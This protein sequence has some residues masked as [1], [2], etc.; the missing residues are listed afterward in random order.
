M[1]T[2]AVT[3]GIAMG[4]STFCRVSED[5]GPSVGLVCQLFDADL[6][7]S[8]LLTDPAITCTIAADFG[9]DILSPDGQIDRPR[10]RERVFNSAEQRAVL[11]NIL[12]PVVRKRFAEQRHCANAGGGV[13]VF[14]ADIPLLYES[15]YCFE[16]DYVLVV[17]SSAGVQM[18]RLLGR[19]GMTETIAA[20]VIAS[21]LPTDEKIARADVVL[22]NDGTE[23]QFTEQID[24]FYQWLKKKTN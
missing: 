17:A 21:Q 19:K 10:L 7:V 15:E 24:C 8:E 9:E 18:R 6:A 13:D 5:L 12:H 3:G 16:H 23:G 20:R 11:E 2:V 22:W 1:L 14:L 4:K